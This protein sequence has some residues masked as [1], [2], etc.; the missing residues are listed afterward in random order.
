MMRWGNAAI[1]I[2][3]GWQPLPFDPLKD[4][5]P[6]S[7][8]LSM[9]SIFFVNNDL[10]VKS[11]ADLIAYAKANPGKLSYGTPGVGTP[12]HVAGELFCPLAGLHSQHI[13]YRHHN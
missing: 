1:T 4:L 3:P 2:R 8:A 7:T 5:A 12:Q 6:I 13:P 9:P 11:I 10:P